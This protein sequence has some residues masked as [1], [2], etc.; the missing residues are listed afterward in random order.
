MPETGYSVD[1]DSVQGLRGQWQRGAIALA[2]VDQALD[3]ACEQV[4]RVALNTSAAKPA[5]LPLFGEA[6]RLLDRARGQAG[7][8][9]V[10]LNADIVR[11]DECAFNYRAAENDVTARLNA[12][13]HGR[14]GKVAMAR[15]SQYTGLSGLSGGGGPNDAA[16]GAGTG[17]G[18]N[19]GTNSATTTG[20]TTG[21]SPDSA[22]APVYS[23]PQ[24]PPG[25]YPNQVQVTAWINEAFGDLEAAGVPAAQLDEPGVLTIVEHESSGDPKAI[26]NWDSNAAAGHPSKGLMQTIDSTFEAYKLPGHDDVYNPVDNIIAGVRYALSRYGSIS[27][28]PGVE[29]VNSGGSYVGY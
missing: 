12:V 27:N 3:R 21:A 4:G 7:R 15:S 9:L 26:N 24:A 10:D 22:S 29:A 23:G 5:G 11:L 1:F 14:P 8:L 13:V 17:S 19:T 18:T 25:L 2:Q 6:V 28:V 20:T 16:D